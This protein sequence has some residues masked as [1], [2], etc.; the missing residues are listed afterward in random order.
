MDLPTSIKYL[1][2]SIISSVVLFFVVNFLLPIMQYKDLL[3]MSILFYSV[4]ALI[5]FILGSISMKANNGK[6]FLA[7]VIFNV[8]FKLVASLVFIAIYAKNTQPQSKYF[9][10]PF[11]LVYLCFTVTETI[12]LS[13]QARSAQ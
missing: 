1:F 3:I 5:L 6:Q 8:L 4:L 7:L 2:I 13:K 12:V 11:L 10:L 9:V